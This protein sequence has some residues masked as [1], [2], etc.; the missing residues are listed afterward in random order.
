MHYS[1]VGI[2][3][4]APSLMPLGQRAVTVLVRV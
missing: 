4:A 1:I 3:N 2:E